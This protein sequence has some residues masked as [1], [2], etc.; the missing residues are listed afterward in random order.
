MFAEMYNGM[1]S[2]LWYCSGVK[3]I[4]QVSMCCKY[5]S[6]NTDDVGSPS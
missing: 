3:H 2:Y 6:A 1:C 4:L 5:V